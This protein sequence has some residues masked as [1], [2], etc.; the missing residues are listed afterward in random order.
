[1]LRDADGLTDVE[2]DRQLREP[3][4][5]VGAARIVGVDDAAQLKIDRRIARDIDPAIDP[6]I[7]VRD[8]ERRHEVL[9]VLLPTSVAQVALVLPSFQ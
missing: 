7:H 4:L 6:G 3:E 5:V 1:M 8:L 9:G 2:V